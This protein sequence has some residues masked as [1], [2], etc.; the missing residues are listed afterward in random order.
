M[1]RSA[2][3]VKTIAKGAAGFL[4]GAG[5]WLSAAGPYHAAIAAPAQFLIRAFESPAATRLG[6]SG[7]EVIVDRGDFPPSSPRP[8]IPAGD[9]D[10]NIALLA[11]LFAASPR[12]LSDRAI[13]RLLLALAVLAAS[14]VVAL[15]FSVESLYAM[16]LG[17]WSRVHYGAVSRNFWAT[18][19]HFYRIAGM[20]AI[21]FVLWWGLAEA[22]AI[23]SRGGPAAARRSRRRA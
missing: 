10:F 21:P 3:R 5:L 19:A 22:P 13:L 1:S 16:D 18:G 17:E 8:G 23:V 11:A 9:L 20:F 6:A 4:A 15:I 14:H 2:K 12:P 7:R